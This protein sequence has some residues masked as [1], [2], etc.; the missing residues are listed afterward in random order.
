MISGN[1]ARNVVPKQPKGFAPWNVFS[2]L[3]LSTE[4]QTTLVKRV[5]EDYGI[6]V[7]ATSNVE[8]ADKGMRSARFD[9]VIC[10]FDVPAANE[11]AC[12]QLSNHWRGVAMGLMPGTRMNHA[13]SKRIQLRMPK[14]VTVDMLVRSLKAS[15]SNMANSRVA[16]YRHTVAAKLVAGTLNHRGWQRTL[17]QVNVLNLSQ[18]GLCLN[19]SEPLPQGAS[20]TM[21]LVL[22]GSASVHASG[23]VVW[24][25]TSGRTGVAFKRSSCPEM[26]K[27]RE[28]LNEWL[29]IDLGLIA[30]AS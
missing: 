12:L 16:T 4:E 29:P 6:L 13:A 11:L 5:L 8:D 26:K 17:H 21:S 14:P 25:H 18:T 2:A 24:S 9:L 10:D 30:R 28:R 3:L 7:H 22:P 20:L 23:S 27:L 15:Y 1:L 19:A